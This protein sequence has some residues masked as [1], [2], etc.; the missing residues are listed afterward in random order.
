[1]LSAVNS[2]CQ[3]S[4]AASR[5]ACWADASHCYVSVS[6]PPLNDSCTVDCPRGI[7]VA[8][9]MHCTAVPCSPCSDAHIRAAAAKMIN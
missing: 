5:D 4:A 1:M 7:C 6:A 9:V 3:C 8:G 2:E